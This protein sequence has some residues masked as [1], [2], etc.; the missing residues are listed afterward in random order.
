VGRN[1]TIVH[2]LRRNGPRWSDPYFTDWGVVVG[3]R[4]RRL[5]QALGWALHELAHR[6][7]KPEGGHYS[8]GYFSRL[9]RG[10]ASAPLYVYLMIAAELDVDAGVLLG[11]DEVQRELSPE[12][13]VL[14][15]VLREA[16]VDPGEAIARLAGLAARRGEQRR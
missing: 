1:Q 4:I 9:E 10:W 16:D 7:R 11:P 5:R 12:E 8:A 15:R 6:V 13:A 2:S 3:D 14:L